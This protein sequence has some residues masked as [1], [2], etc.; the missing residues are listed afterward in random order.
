MKRVYILLV[1]ILIGL[2][3]WFWNVTVEIGAGDDTPKT[4]GNVAPLSPLSPKTGTA[5]N[6]APANA[7]INA[8]GSASVPKTPAT[9]PTTASVETLAPKDEKVE[10]TIAKFVFTPS[11]LKIKRGTTV[12]WTNKDDATHTISSDSGLFSSGSIIKGNSYSFTFEKAGTYPYICGF[13]LGMQ[14]IV[15]V[16]E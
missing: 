13:H 2:G 15:E 6:T 1:I 5:P 10:V 11:P 9:P 4:A 8:E 3:V 16:V 14:G 7:V 12:V